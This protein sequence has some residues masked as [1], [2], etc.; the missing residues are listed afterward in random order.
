MAN[1]NPNTSGL[2]PFKPGTSG[3][4]GG[5]TAEQAEKRKANRDKAFAIE[6][7]LLK[8][9]ADDMTENEAAVLG[10][11]RGDVLRLIHT[12]IERVDGK[13]KS[14]VDLS[15]EDGSMSQPSKIEIIS[16]G[17]DALKAKHGVDSDD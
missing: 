14:S 12:A 8:A 15:S 6:E 13:P 7:R 16:V 5:L 9:L 11:I 4:P 2:K 3:N 17:V 10:H 1:P